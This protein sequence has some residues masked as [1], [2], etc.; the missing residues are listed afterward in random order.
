MLIL[1]KEVIKII[2]KPLAALILR[3]IIRRN[4]YD[5]HFHNLLSFG[6]SNIDLKCYLNHIF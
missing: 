6:F 5:L 4:I 3:C 2:L 1:Y